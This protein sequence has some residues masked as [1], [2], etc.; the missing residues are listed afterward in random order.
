VYALF[1]DRI[2]LSLFIRILLNFITISLWHQASLLLTKWRS[3]PDLFLFSNY[4]KQTWLFDLK[5]WYEGAALG[6]PSTNNGLE[7]LNAKIKQQYTWRNRLCL[8]KFL[9]TM[10]TMLRDWSTKTT[11]AEFQ[12]FQQL[13]VNKK[14]KRGN[15]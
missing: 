15:G 12:T 14:K 5:F 11:E 6:C 2:S 4:F 10:E 8:S 1:L 9:L 3:D 7:S 13:L